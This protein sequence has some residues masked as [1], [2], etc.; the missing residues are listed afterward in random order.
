MVV[1]TKEFGILDP[2]LPIVW[3][4]VPKKT[5]FFTPSLIR[6]SCNRK[7]PWWEMSPKSVSLYGEEVT[8]GLLIPQQMSSNPFKRIFFRFSIHFQ[9]SVDVS[10][11][12][13][14]CHQCFC[15]SQLWGEGGVCPWEG[16]GGAARIDDN[17]PES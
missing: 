12:D 8:I 17:C 1:F 15:S 7:S 2:N 16:G 4:K 6:L 11:T 3:D 10:K 13:L 5:V 9:Q 14:C